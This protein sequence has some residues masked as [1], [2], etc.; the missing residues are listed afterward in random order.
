MLFAELRVITLI[1]KKYSI[2]KT[3]TTTGK[4]PL[5]GCCVALLSKSAGADQ[6]FSQH[7]IIYRPTHPKN[8]TPT[9]GVSPLPTS[10]EEDSSKKDFQRSQIK[11]G[12]KEPL[13]AHLSIVA[14]PAF[15]LSNCLR[16]SFSC[17]MGCRNER[18]ENPNLGPAKAILQ[19]D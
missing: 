9:G 15:S 2:L 16:Y 18:R 3:T 11:C 4:T 1:T 8:R 12:R 7:P 14:W 5:A 19:N 17:G 6:F 13:S 10:T